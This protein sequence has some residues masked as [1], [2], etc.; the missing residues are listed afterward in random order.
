[1]IENKDIKQRNKLEDKRLVWIYEE[2]YKFLELKVGE[3][4]LKRQ[5]EGYLN[6]TPQS[7]N[8]VYKR[9]LESLKNRQGFVNFIAKI[10]SM[11]S[12]LLDFSPN[13]IHLKYGNDWEKLFKDFEKIFGD[14]YKMDINN[15]RNSWV[16]FTKGVISGA[17][18]LS[19]FKIVKDFDNF[20]HS[21]FYNEFTIASLPMLLEK[22]IFGLGFPLACDLLK[23]LGYIQ[24]GKSDVHLKDIFEQLHIS[25]DVSDYEVFKKIVKIGLLVNQPPV[26]VDKIFWLIGS[27]RFY[28][29][30][31]NIGKQ[32][33]EFVK[34][35]LDKET[36]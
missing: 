24:Y 32:K 13:D 14:K 7:L 27:G 17:K 2:A 16:I 20:V 26:I 6:Q 23:E 1:M 30:D 3:D 18:F 33:A 21:F 11:D 34:Y 19:N 12:I 25:E 35:I 8:I 31:I 28:E 36:K 15:K 9:L 29:S 4:V 10:E 22:E 5:F